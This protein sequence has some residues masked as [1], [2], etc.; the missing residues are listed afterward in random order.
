M[1]Q[2]ILQI[3]T[4][5]LYFVWHFFVIQFVIWLFFFNFLKHR[6][7]F[8][9]EIFFWLFPTISLLPFNLVL[10][11][12]YSHDFRNVFWSFW[13]SFIFFFRL[14]QVGA[15]AGTACFLIVFILSTD[16]WYTMYMK[17]QKQALAEQLGLKPRQVEVWFQ[18][19][20][21]RLQF[22]SNIYWVILS[23][24]KLIA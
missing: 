12:F 10:L 15:L 20:R 14:S 5:V 1:L 18:N 13:S 17:A 16:N 4:D 8:K 11:R 21:A 6:L 24:T 19:R 9:N 22:F 3:F 23:H 7:D 2:N